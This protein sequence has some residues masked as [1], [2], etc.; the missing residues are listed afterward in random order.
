ML[1]CPLALMPPAFGLGQIVDMLAYAENLDIRPTL[2]TN[3]L[4]VLRQFVTRGNGAT[5]ISAFSVYR[6]IDAGELV[7]LPISH[8]IF[9][10]A[11]ARV[12]VKARRPLSVAAE[13]LLEW[14]VER[15]TVFARGS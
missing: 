11:K 6:E 7:A 12:L 10:T 15:M 2:T 4:Q 3:S 1:A 5:L 13:Q 9:E 14:I 8:P